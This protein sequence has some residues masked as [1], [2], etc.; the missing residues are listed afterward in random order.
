MSS[1]GNLTKP[2]DHVNVDASAAGWDQI[3]PAVT[4]KSIV[5]CDVIVHG[6]SEGQLST[7]SDG[8]GLITYTV[9]GHTPYRAPIR[10]PVSK[11]VYS[12]IEAKHTITYYLI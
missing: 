10:V 9:D 2:G 7:E 6:S 1:L 12:N 11:P 5:L 4:G 8:T 3:I